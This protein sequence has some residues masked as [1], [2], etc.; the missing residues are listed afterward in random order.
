MEKKLTITELTRYLVNRYELN[1]EGRS[2]MNEATEDGMY[3]YRKNVERILQKT[4]ILETSYYEAC[5]PKDGGTRKLSV[6]EF[7]K[8]CFGQ[9]YSYVKKQEKYNKLLL[10]ADYSRLCIAKK[11]EIDEKMVT[12]IIEEHN[13]ILEEMDVA[14]YDDCHESFETRVKNYPLDTKL[15]LSALK[16]MITGIFDIFYEPFDWKLFEA[17]VENY[18]QDLSYN[19]DI[20]PEMLKSIERLKSIHSYAKRRNFLYKKT[21]II[22]EKDETVKKK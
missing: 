4:K 20:T 5:K 2:N 8:F 9:W 21:E 18:P 16:L 11:E 14:E 10:E 19:P 6:D 3:S 7:E 22:K 1:T 15:E 17:D 13:N 12:D